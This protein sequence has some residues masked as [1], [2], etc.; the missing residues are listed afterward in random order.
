MRWFWNSILKIINW[1]VEGD[2]PAGM[3]KFVLVVA[4]HTSN[5]DFFL[6]VIARGALG[7]HANYLGKSNLFKPPF[8]FFFRALGGIPVDRSR[9]SNLVDQVVS[10]VHRRKKFGL[11]V[12]PEGTRKKVDQWKTGFYYIAVKAGIP[13]IPVQFDWEKRVIRFLEPFYPT[14]DLGRDLPVIQSKFASIRGKSE[15]K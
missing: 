5:W 1:K 12:A 8:G 2:V 10:Q 11:A 7:F 3:I 15:S 6:G 9:N 14:A 4:P 13:I